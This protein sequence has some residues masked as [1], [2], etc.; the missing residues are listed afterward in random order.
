A[1]PKRKPRARRAPKPKPAGQAVVSG[2]STEVDTQNETG[3]QIVD[4][5]PAG[6]APHGEPVGENDS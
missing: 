2:E 4:I 6:I 5:E 3:E 1:A